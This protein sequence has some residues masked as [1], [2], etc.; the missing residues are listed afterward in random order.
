MN[1]KPVYIGVDPAFRA[2]G[3]W[4]CVLDMQDRSVRFI[5]YRDLLHWHDWLRSGDA[6]DQAFVAV[7]NSNAQN[8]TFARHLTGKVSEQVRKSRNVGT[9]QAVSQLAYESAVR[10]YG[11]SRV[12]SVSPQD[13]GRKYTPAQFAQV[14]QQDGVTLPPGTNNQDQRDAYKLADIARRLALVNRQFATP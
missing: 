9:N 5:A 3:F 12:F 14:V 4:A 10:H 11:Q 13:K 2:G 1:A 6:P 8:K 7:E